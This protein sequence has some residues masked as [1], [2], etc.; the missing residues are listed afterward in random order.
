VAT[1]VIT[2]FVNVNVYAVLLSVPT[3]IVVLIPD[4]FSVINPEALTL[5]SMVNFSLGSVVPSPK[6]PAEI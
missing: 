6:F 1:F 3:L 5:P 2:P 4:R